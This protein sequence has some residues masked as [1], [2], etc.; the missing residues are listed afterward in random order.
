MRRVVVTGMA[1]LSPIGN[2][3][4]S[5]REN[6]LAK[7]NGVKR[8]DWDQFEGLRT[9]LGAPIPPF[10]KPA[11]F[12]RKRTRSMGPVA[13]YATYS[14]ELALQDAGLLEHPIL[15]SG[16]AGVAYGTS[17]GSPEAIAD[18]AR[19]YLQN[20]LDS[21]TG[22]SYI[23]MMPHT[24]ST[25]IGVFFG[26]Q[27]RNIPTSTACTSGSLAIG[28]AYEA[29]KEG[30]QTVMIAGGGEELC[31]TEASVFDVLYATD[32]SNDTPELVPKPFDAN[33]KGLV[34]GEGAGTFILEDYEFAK[35]RGATIYAEVAGFGTNSDGV[36][37]TQPTARTMQIAME[38]A[39][40]DAGI[41]PKDIDY[42]NGHGTA[43]D[44]GDIEESQATA[45]LFGNKIPFAS[46]KGY[47]GHTLGAAGSLEAWMSIQMMRENWFAPNLNLTTVDEK[48]GDLNYIIGDKIDLEA[49]YIMSNNFAFGG[50]NTSLVFKR[51]A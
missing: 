18:F 43:T 29:I 2:D 12:T 51:W 22:N 32:I 46:L 27:G 9:R 8:M 1:G 36:H 39:L 5:V 35:K 19:I 6:L 33:R 48:C 26:L 24:T 23:K 17:T 25:N 40:K 50:V 7:K 4:Q 30:K 10:E 3:W 21:L 34:V 15:Q 20:S 49:N 44:A 13:L 45:N 16:E 38:L 47:I 37:V 28:L 11:H 31:P 41:T 42:I 14:S